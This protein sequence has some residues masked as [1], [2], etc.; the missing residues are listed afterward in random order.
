MSELEAWFAA[1]DVAVAEASDGI[2]GVPIEALA[3]HLRAGGE[4]EELPALAL[5]DEIARLRGVVNARNDCGV[6]TAMSSGA[7]ADK[8]RARLTSALAPTRWHGHLVVRMPLDDEL[9]EFDDQRS[10]D[11]RGWFGAWWTVNLWHAE[12]P[13]DAFTVDSE[14]AFRSLVERRCCALVESGECGERSILVTTYNDGTHG[15]YCEVHGIGG[16]Q[17]TQQHPEVCIDAMAQEIRGRPVVKSLAWHP[18]RDGR[19]GMWKMD[20]APG[21]FGGPRH[22]E[23]AMIADARRVAEFVETGHWQRGTLITWDGTDATLARIRELADAA[24]L[25]TATFPGPVVT[26]PSRW[27]SA[28]ALC[29]QNGSQVAYARIGARLTFDGKYLHLDPP[30]GEGPI[31][32]RWPL[33]CSRDPAP[34]PGTTAPSHPPTPPPMTF[35]LLGTTLRRSRPTRT[36]M[37]MVA[38]LRGLHAVAFSCVCTSAELPAPAAGGVCKK[39]RGG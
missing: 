29:V 1:V 30:V 34:A 3:E 8:L 28:P 12:G 35:P 33:V 18:P 37:V 23:H 9:G 21:E 19:C 7:C 11:A 24:E 39:W 4:L 10:E 13:R 2:A 27:E 14:A 22:A 26:H 31:Q 17:P 38:W 15:A 20:L 32:R 25:T 6:D 36:D 5:L 16:G